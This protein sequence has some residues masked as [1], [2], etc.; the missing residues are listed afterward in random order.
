M[1]ASGSLPGSCQFLDN[2]DD[3][4]S[5]VATTQEN[6]KRLTKRLRGKNLTWWT[7]KQTKSGGLD[8]AD[9]LTKAGEFGLR[10]LLVEGG[11]GL[12]TSFLRAQLVDK[13][14]MV[15]APILIGR[16]IDAIGD[17]GIR[18]LS[19]NI[20]LDNVSMR[21]SGRDAVITGYPN[22]RK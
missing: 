19:R 13:V 5:I 20:G 12:A 7:I 1:T 3:L 14:V 2:N 15:V 11:S 9:L 8:L 16:G 21:L 4:R 22:Y 10:S 18:K 17:L 6:A